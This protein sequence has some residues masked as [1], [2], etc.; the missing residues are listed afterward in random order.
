MTTTTESYENV[1]WNSCL[2]T[3][4]HTNFDGMNI[5]AS[6]VNLVNDMIGNIIDVLCKN[7][8]KQCK[9]NDKECMSYE[10]V[11]AELENLIPSTSKCT[12]F[13]PKLCDAIE[14]KRLNYINSYFP[15]SDVPA[16]K[17]KQNKKDRADVNINMSLVK[18]Y[19]ENQHFIPGELAVVLITSCLDICVNELLR[20]STKLTKC[21]GKKTLQINDIFTTVEMCEHL[22]FLMPFLPEQTDDVNE[23]EDEDEVNDE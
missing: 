15:M 5:T 13:L 14:E 6:S 16:E 19:I 9:D 7:P 10:I 1:K 4:F 22:T 20:C 8:A 17:K 3:L 2:R 18:R 21:G 12:C 11:Y 23:N